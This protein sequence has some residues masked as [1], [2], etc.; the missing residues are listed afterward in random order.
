MTVFF[1]LFFFSFF[2]KK[3]DSSKHSEMSYFDQ[4]PTETLSIIIDQGCWEDLRSW[5]L[6]S[7]KFYD[8][9]VST[10]DLKAL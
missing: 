8:L 7:K 9:C 1:L 2:G 4:Y 5:A 6:V 3:H 10:K